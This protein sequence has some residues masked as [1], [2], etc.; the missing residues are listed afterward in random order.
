LGDA[1]EP[2]GVDGLAVLAALWVT[3]LAAVLSL[4]AYQRHPHV[5]DEVGYLYHARYFAEGVL[6]MPTPPVPE[7]F[8]IDL[9]HYEED[10]W[11][12]PVP[13]AWPAMLAL[14]ALLGAPWLVNRVVT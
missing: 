12:S 7:A 6:T 5:A 4:T 14:G 13:P 9:M 10:R 1:E 2:R 8:D 11:Y 3:V